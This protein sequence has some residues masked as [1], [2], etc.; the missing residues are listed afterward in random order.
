M[1]KV[2][3]LSHLTPREWKT[4]WNENVVEDTKKNVRAVDSRSCFLG[5]FENESDFILYYHKEFENNS[6]NTFFMGHVESAEEGCRVTGYY[7]KKKTANIFLI[8]AMIITAITTVV[9]LFGGMGQM[10]I[11]PAAL[12]AICAVCFFTIPKTTKELLFER[13]KKI[14]FSE[15]KRDRKHNKKLESKAAKTADKSIEDKIEDA[16]GDE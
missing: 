1:E 8:F 6:L 12:C 13:L 3:I 4:A 16:L 7:A 2:E 5:H 15:S 10:V 11:A 14:S 9:M